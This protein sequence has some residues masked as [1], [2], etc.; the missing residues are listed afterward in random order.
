MH[1]S[2]SIA[3]PFNR[4]LPISADAVSL[5]CIRYRDSAVSGGNSKSGELALLE[6]SVGGVED[7]DGGELLLDALGAGFACLPICPGTVKGLRCEPND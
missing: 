3:H 4:R 2:A 1:S 6:T 7:R 5:C